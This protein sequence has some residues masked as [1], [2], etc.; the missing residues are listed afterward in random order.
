M[1]NTWDKKLKEP[2]IYVALFSFAAI[3][4]V[5]T[6]A[7]L[8]ILCSQAWV[9]F[10]KVSPVN[11]FLG[12]KWTPLFEP[13]Q[14]GILPLLA[15]TLL[16]AVLSIAIALPIGLGI[17]IYL[18]Q[19]ASQRIKRYF[20]PI[21]ELLAGVP[22]VVYGYFALVTISP[23]IQKVFP[24]SNVFNALSASIVV[25]IMILPMIA[26]ISDDALRALP[27]NLAESGYAL[28]ATP[29]EV[30]FSVLIPSA[31]SGIIAAVILGLSRA[32]GETMAV[33]L[34]AGATPNL[35]A[36][37]LES[38]QTM[39]AY[40]VQISLGD[41]EY[42]SVQYDSIFA[43]ALVLFLLTLSMNLFSNLILRKVK[44]RFH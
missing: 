38:I 12:T 41:V 29:F 44:A 17:A 3:S 4:I 25:A 7:I 8:F 21:L 5:V 35:T 6:L 39:T 16:I 22:S 36:N 1:L 34:A 30:V 27:A 43:V 20:K 32:I 10:T 9:F 31:S 37:P 28:G 18:S 13:Q 42:G 15:G 26:S 24:N 14:F 19:F 23:I 40:I 11:F 33:T 2:I